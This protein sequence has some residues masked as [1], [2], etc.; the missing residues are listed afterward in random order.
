MREHLQT[1]TR[2]LVSPLIPYYSPGG[3]RVRL[4]VNAALHDDAAAE[5][6]SFARPLWGLAPLAAGGGRFDHWDLVRRGLAS[7]TDPAHEEYWREP[8]D[9]D[10]RI[11]EMAAI[12]FALALAPERLWD[13]LSGGE[14]DRLAAWLATALARDTSDNNWR[15][16]GVLV[17]LGLSRVGV[18]HDRAAVTERLDRLETY[19]LGD[20]WYSDGPTERR[21]YYVSFAM[22]FYGL[23]YA[24]LSADRARAERFRER[25]AVFAHDFQH[26]FAADGAAVPYGRSLT[27]RFAQGAFW[28]ALAF[29]GVE[30]L[31]WGVVKGQLLRHLRWWRARPIFTADGLLSVGYGYAQPM[32]AEQY[33]APGSPYWAMKAMLPLAL[34]ATHPFWTAPEL[35][36]PDLPGV[37]AQPH[38]GAVL[39]RAER[40]RHVVALSARQHHMWV[41]HGAEKYAK[42][43]YSTHFG[44]SVPGGYAGLE[45]GAHDS[46]LALS[47]D[48]VHYRVR[49]EPLD[50]AVDGDTL[51]SRWRPWP[52]V[53][54][55]T[56][57]TAAPP[58]HV[59]THRIVTARA[60]HTAEGGFAI[61][62]EPP[63]EREAAPG[64]ACARGRSG[65]SAIED[66]SACRTGRLVVAL[67]GTNV[68]AP[69]TEIP[70]LVEDLPPGEH[71]RSAAVLGL[72][73]PGADVPPPPDAPVRRVP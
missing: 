58:W 67:P 19:A 40:G 2:E 22:H 42:F 48:G 1:W 60:L 3:A 59:R 63:L 61:D 26:W 71:W 33:N 30:A 21:D 39:M 64:R 6:E 43:A 35:A 49:E 36:A 12:G 13:P 47:E 10:Q 14:R 46:M 29:A 66:L 73:D 72:T 15:F 68:A 7:G 55:E 31:P 70:T 11:V 24:A 52:D 38:A 51:Y 16:F 27:Y 53:E 57:L 18:R 54:V 65:V 41:R 4:G 8:R 50:H 28:G 9:S 5:L 45:H 62:R 34:P 20:G 56:W 23:V 44:F 37:R 17:S 25:A 32:L 69:R